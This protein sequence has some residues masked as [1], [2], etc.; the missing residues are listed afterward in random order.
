MSRTTT[1]R[2]F[3]RTPQSHPKSMNHKEEGDGDSHSHNRLHRYTPTSETA[4]SDPGRDSYRVPMRS[5]A[6]TWW[7]RWTQSESTGPCWFRRSP[8][9][10]YDATYA[11]EVYEKH[12]GKFGLIKPFDP[13]SE[14][15]ADEMAEWTSTPGV[16]GAR[17]MLAYGD[18]EA[19]DPGLNRILAAG[20]R[21]G[22][23]VNVM[24]S[25]KLPLL[26]ELASRHPDTQDR[27]RSRGPGPALRAAAGAGTIC[28]PGQRDF[29]GRIRQRGHQD[30]RGLYPLPRAI[31][32]S[33]HL[34]VSEQGI[35]RVRLRSMHVGYRL[36][37]CGGTVDLRAGRRV[38]PGHRPAFGLGAQRANGRNAGEDLRLVARDGRIGRLFYTRS[39]PVR[40]RKQPYQ[41]SCQPSPRLLP[42]TPAVLVG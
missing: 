37:S 6:T 1:L 22:V 33:R 24:C 4:L 16:V 8:C 34:G 25:G 26:R 20:A 40:C 32:V 15:I 13:Q 42:L 9:T 12:P 27:D 17:I 19:D 11:L 28:R 18:F 7:R 41:T 39:G 30:F 5:P 21:A 3:G 38:V 10:G 29:A 2:S 23:P 35:R 14:S 31:P 36:D